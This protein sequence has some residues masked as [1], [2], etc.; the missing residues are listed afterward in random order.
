MFYLPIICVQL[1]IET[2]HGEK[3]YLMRLRK[4]MDDKGNGNQRRGMASSVLPYI[5]DWSSDSAIWQTVDGN[6]RDRLSMMLQSEGLCIMGNLPKLPI[7]SCLNLNP[8]SQKRRHCTKLLN[9]ENGKF[10]NAGH[11]PFSK[12]SS[13]FLMRK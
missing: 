9:K 6:T 12:I 1:Q 11:L 10:L 7:I 13:V 2:L 5:G 3:L 8:H 4:T